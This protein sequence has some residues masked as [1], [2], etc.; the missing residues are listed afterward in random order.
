MQFDPSLVTG[1][2]LFLILNILAI[3]HIENED[4]FVALSQLG[5]QP[6][7]ELEHS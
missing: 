4:I 7:T 5:L 1:Q 6:V 2:L 3:T